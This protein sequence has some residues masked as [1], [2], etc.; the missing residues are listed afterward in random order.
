MVD[1]LRWGVGLGEV[2][3]VGGRFC[4]DRGL[5]WGRMSVFVGQW[6]YGEGGGGGFVHARPPGHASHH[7]PDVGEVR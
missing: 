2:V 5:F 4:F 7:T 6:L 3:W 1:L